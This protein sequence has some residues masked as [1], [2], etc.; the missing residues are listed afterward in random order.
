MKRRSFGVLIAAIALCLSACGS[1]PA[2]QAPTPSGLVRVDVGLIPVAEYFTVYVAQ[3]QGF[4]KQ[5]GLDVNVQVMSNAASIVPSVINGQLTFGTTATPPFLEA[6]EKGLPLKGVSASASTPSGAENDTGAVLVAQGSS[7]QKVTDLA[8][9]K[10]AVNQLG[11]LPQVVVAARIKQE[12]GDPKAVNFVAMPFPDMA[13]ALQ[14][15]RVD[16]ILTVEPFLTKALQSGGFRSIAPLYAGVYPSGTTDTLIFG[17]SQ[18]VQQNAA[19]VLKFQHALEQADQLVTQNPQVLRDTLVKHGGVSQPV[20]N[21]IKLPTYAA[22]F[23]TSGMQ[24]VADLMQQTGFL[25]K[26]IDVAGTLAVG[27]K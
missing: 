17:S 27:A 7:I 11:A 9:K 23:N 26:R 22:Q 19:T 2:T 3:D 25:S 6:V 16:A 18:Y 13:G 4:F 21:A 8:G 12:G 24:N 5:Q 20:A 10:V 14:Q 1:G 15:G